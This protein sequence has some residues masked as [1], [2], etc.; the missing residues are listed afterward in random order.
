MNITLTKFERTSIVSLATAKLQ[1]LQRD[2]TTER[3]KVLQGIQ[4]SY[5]KSIG[6]LWWKVKKP[7]TLEQAEELLRNSNIFDIGTYDTYR[8]KNTILENYDTR[9]LNRIISTKLGNTNESI[10]L[11]LYEYSL[12][13]A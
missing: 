1:Q 5:Y 11:D 9:F 4:S 2:Y 8:Y 6:Y 7:Y 10:E 13:Y 12:I 3:N